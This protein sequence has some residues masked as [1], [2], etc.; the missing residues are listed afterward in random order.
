MRKAKHDPAPLLAV[1][2]ARGGLNACLDKAK[3]ENVLERRTYQEPL[4]SGTRRGG[5]TTSIVDRICVD[6]LD[7]LPQL[8]YGE[9]WWAA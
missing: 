7:T 6:V 5:L 9:E 2:K 1:L 4:R 3:I 8:V